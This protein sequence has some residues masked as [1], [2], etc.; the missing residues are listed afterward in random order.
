MTTG[1]KERVWNDPP[2]LEPE[3]PGITQEPRIPSNVI[4]ISP[5]GFLKWKMGFIGSV[6]FLTGLVIYY[7]IT[8][9]ETP[10]STFSTMFI[11]L[12]GLFFIIS[13]LIPNP[14]IR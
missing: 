4:I 1:K 6:Y 8:Y 14:R 12:G 11:G 7:F 5:Q 9:T 13:L 3:I 2:G 10:V